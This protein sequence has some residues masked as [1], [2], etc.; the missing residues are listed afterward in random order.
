M[1]SEAEEDIRHGTKLFDELGEHKT[2]NFPLFLLLHTGRRTCKRA[3]PDTRAN[4]RYD[5]QCRASKSPHEKE[6]AEESDAL[7]RRA[8]RQTS[9]QMIAQGQVTAQGSRWMCNDFHI[10]GADRQRVKRDNL[11]L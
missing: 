1:A 8:G 2:I 11:N 3:R 6:L 4:E 7:S 9:S 10:K 5:H